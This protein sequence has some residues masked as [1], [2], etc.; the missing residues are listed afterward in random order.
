VLPRLSQLAE[1]R[2]TTGRPLIHV[3]RIHRP[4][5]SNVDLCRR[6]MVRGAPVPAPGSE[7]VELTR[8][9]PAGEVE[10]DRERL[11][12]AEPVSVGEREWV[13]YKPRRSAF[14]QT[15]LG[16]LLGRL[17]VSTVVVAGCNFPT[18]RPAWAGRPPVARPRRGRIGT[19]DRIAPVELHGRLTSLVPL[20]RTHVDGV[21]AAARDE[22]V[23]TW[24]PY[25]GLGEVERAGAWIGEALE[26]RE[27][28]QRLPFAIVDRAETRVIGSTSYWGYDA[29]SRH[30]EIGSSWLERS[31]WGMGRNLEAKLLL[32]IH[33]FES[34]E[35]ERVEFQTDT[36]NR[37]SRRAIEG[38]GAVAE[39]VFRHERPRRDGSWR[40]SARYAILSAEWPRC[41]ASIEDRL[42]GEYGRQ[43][44]PG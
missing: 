32:L 27:S 20:A 8:D 5:G 19:M 25:H 38:L 33:A 34:M 36:M 21:A 18:P 15:G 11:L 4:D 43:S 1:R 2:R 35:L 37:R 17:E 23:F 13:M 44:A 29:A 31:C 14:Q 30:L 9:L 6:M 39:G 7:G 24:L 12:T 10:Y 40:D 16:E 42:G 26:Q 3:M 41:K 22:E 28:G